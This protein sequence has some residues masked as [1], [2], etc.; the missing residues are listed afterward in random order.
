MRR[1]G[2]TYAAGQRLIPNA[3]H[4]TP[5]HQAPST[6]EPRAIKSFFGGSNHVLI[7]WTV[8]D[9]TRPLEAPFALRVE[10]VP[11]PTT[12][13]LAGLACAGLLTA[14]LTTR[15]RYRAIA[16]YHRRHTTPAATM[17]AQARP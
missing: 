13:A 5:P 1:G 17:G 10:A 7:P 12:A 2:R 11:E 6:P 16:A 3:T 14:R 15:R 8:V 9:L 4:N